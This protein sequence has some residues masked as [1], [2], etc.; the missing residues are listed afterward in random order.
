[1]ALTG[2]A[3]GPTLGPQSGLVERLLGVAADITRLAEELHAELSI[4]PLA[5]LGERAALTALTRAGATSCGGATRL[6]PTATGW[7]AVGLPRPEDAELVPAWLESGDVDT[8]DP[9]T[10]ISP[11]L[12]ERSTI[13]LEARGALLGLAVGALPARPR[14]RPSSPIV[15]DRVADGAPTTAITD[16]VIADLSSLWAGPLCGSLFA[17]S[18][19]TVIKVESSRRPDGSRSGPEAFFDLMNGGKR[20][21]A[22]DLDD[23][24]GRVT[25]ASLLRRADVVIEASRPRALEQMGIDARGLLATGRPRVWISI[26]GHGRTPSQRDRIGFGDDAAVAGGL[27]SWDDGEPVFCADAI[28]DPISGV[29]ATAAALDHLRRGGAWLIDIALARTAAWCTGPA[30]PTP[31]VGAVDVA[32][33]RARRPSGVGPALGADTDE[34]LDLLDIAT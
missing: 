15:A 7:L 18:G 4:D 34:V 2:R 16:L 23:P 26:T 31:G 32:P 5:L 1:M 13:D 19:A 12:R 24:Q 14:L 27:V 20:S 6:M 10:W 30:I 11:R 25:L 29:V 28:A 8:D 3:D 17:A 22:L 21:V 9:W 33:P